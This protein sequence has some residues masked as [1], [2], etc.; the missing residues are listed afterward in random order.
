[1][2]TNIHTGG[3]KSA[4]IYRFIC[5]LSVF[6]LNNYIYYSL[7]RTQ[8]IKGAWENLQ[9][10]YANWAQIAPNAHFG[11]AVEKFLLH[12]GRCE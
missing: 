5:K 4:Q 7:A 12:G 8:A 2:Y 6:K 3:Y 11:P 1:M 9:A 10:S